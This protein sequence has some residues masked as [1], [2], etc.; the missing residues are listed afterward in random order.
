MSFHVPLKSTAL[1]PLVLLGHHTSENCSMRNR[2]PGSSGL[3]EVGLDGDSWCPCK[4]SWVIVH[5]YRS[6]LG[7]GTPT[8]PRVRA[9]LVLSY[10]T[11]DWNP[12][13]S[14]V[15]CLTLGCWSQSPAPKT[16]WPVAT[17]DLLCLEEGS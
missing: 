13:M 15:A 7:M 17:Y 5:Y 3:W 4:C 16:L 12:D 6:G 9:Q 8:E 14:W 1:T 10:Y 11:H 2:L